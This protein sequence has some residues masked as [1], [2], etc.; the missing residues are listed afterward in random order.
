MFLRFL[1]TLVVLLAPTLAHAQSV[2]RLSGDDVTF[3]FA[4][5]AQDPAHMGSKISAS[6]KASSNRLCGFQVRGNHQSG[7]R[8]HIEWDLNIDQV[9]TPNRTVA[10]VSAGT[11]EV[12][13]HKRTPR[14]PITDLSFVLTGT[15]EPIVAAIQ[16]VPNADGGIVALLEAEPASRL[17]D[18]FQTMRPIVISL[19]YSDGSS[20]RLE[21]RGFRDDRKFGGG[22]NS[23]FNECLRGFRPTLPGEIATVVR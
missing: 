2:T 20:D 13:E 12:T 21:V 18:E 4:G 19:Q 9:V 7:A 16:G 10:G 11:F 23:Y 5:V 6:T 17:F 14:A 22:K 15:P 3:H 1:M 8:S